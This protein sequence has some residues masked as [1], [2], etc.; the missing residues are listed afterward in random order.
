MF[1]CVCVFG[2]FA[3]GLVVWFGLFVWF[4]C[5]VVWFGL[6]VWLFGFDCLLRLVW[7]G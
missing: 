2:L 5:L 3:F 7:Y 4:V 1:V 6:F